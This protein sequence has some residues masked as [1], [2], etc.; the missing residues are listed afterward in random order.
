MK[1]FIRILALLIVIPF[2]A[3]AAGRVLEPS[4]DTTSTPIAGENPSGNAQNFSVDA[5]GILNV[6]LSSTST[7]TVVHG[8]ITIVAN[9]AS[10]R[11]TGPSTAVTS[12]L[13]QSSST[14]IDLVYF[15]GTTLTNKSGGNES[16]SLVPAQFYSAVGLSNLNE[17]N[18][19]SDTA[20]Q[21]VY[22]VC[23]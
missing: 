11:Y 13:F 21:E 12:C 8:K 14:N 6:N 10:D 9:G 23:N 4:G 20:G 5:N 19:A 17:M 22:Y 1:K 18:F 16:A 7:V 15:G 2:V 3:Y